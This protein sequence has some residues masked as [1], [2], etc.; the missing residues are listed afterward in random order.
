[1][2][3]DTITDIL[4]MA[5]G[6]ALSPI[7]IAAVVSILLATDSQKASTFLLGWATGIL[8]I[9]LLVLFIPG[10]RML[11]GDP[12]PLAGWLRICLGTVLLLIAVLKWKKRPPPQIHVEEPKF[13]TKIDSYNSWKTLI[14]G[15]TMS[16]LNPKSLVLVSASAMTIYESKIVG[17]E[18]ASVLLMFTVIA[19]L[20][21]AIP[22][23]LTWAQPE[24]A[25]KILEDLKNWLIA[26]NMA[27]T[28]AL[29][30]VFA[31]I[32]AG[33]GVKLIF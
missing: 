14:L 16:T 8:A 31:L 15:V 22:I 19:S 10:L 27:V 28:V 1:M 4:P 20:S 17:Q 23:L 9:G 25:Q 32:I 6:I 13:L 24:K 30:V 12:T 21:V 2:V 3:L 26:N 5:A 29:L 33:N 11:N 7:P 18:K